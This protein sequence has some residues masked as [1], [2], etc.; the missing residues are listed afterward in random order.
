MEYWAAHHLI[1]SAT[2]CQ[3]NGGGK[4]GLHED[5]AE[6]T[7]A[8]PAVLGPHLSIWSRSRTGPGG[9]FC[10][11]NVTV[12][13]TYPL[14]NMMDFSARIA[15]CQIFTKIDLRKDYYQIFM[16]PADIPKTAIMAC[17]SSC[18]YLLA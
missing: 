18:G 10:R 4:G 12:P 15:G 1:V 6:G 5:R 11:L 14:P 9:D 7:P 13:D 3:K 2:R 16:H 17:L 8:A